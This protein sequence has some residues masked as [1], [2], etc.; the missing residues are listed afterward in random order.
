M[1]A[2]YRKASSKTGES[3]FSVK[4]R[5]AGNEEFELTAALALFA[6]C[7]RGVDNLT[8]FCFST[9]IRSI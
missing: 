9:F 1:K 6:E 3:L 4:V 7:A 2:G 8:S 5:A